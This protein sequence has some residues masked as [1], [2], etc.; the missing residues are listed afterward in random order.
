MNKR[1]HALKVALVVLTGLLLARAWAGF[2]QSGGG[3]SPEA[4]AAV[5]WS[6]VG[7][8][9][10][11]SPTPAGNILMLHSIHAQDLTGTNFGGM[12]RQINSN[13]TFFGL[14]PDGEAGGDHWASQTVRTGFNTYE[15]TLL[16]Y[17]TRKGTGPLAETVAIGVLNADWTVTGPNTNEGTATISMYLAAQDADRDG[18]PDAGQEPAICMPFTY[19]SRRLTP[20][21]GCV[22]T[23]VPQQT[24]Q[25]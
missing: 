8:W 24:P 21:P 2:A 17:L 14:I 10:V 20:M 18:L 6:P 19:T 25:Q 15:S 22:P 7:T 13:P 1:T 12:L 9:L 3:E 4:G 5:A 16:Y 23:P 11:S